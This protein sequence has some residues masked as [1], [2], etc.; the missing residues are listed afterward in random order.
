[1]KFLNFFMDK[2]KLVN[3]LT[4][5]LLLAGIISVSNINREAMPKV[6]FDT[7]FVITVYPGAAMED[8]EL[9]VTIPLEEEISS[10][11]GIKTMFSKT[12]EGYSYI[13]VEIDPDVK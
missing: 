7:V 5:G 1:M 6:D 4:I 11:D 12:R 10:V 3:M 2:T 13:D 8:V 9:D